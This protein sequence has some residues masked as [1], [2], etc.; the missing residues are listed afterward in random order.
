[1]ADK[2][3]GYKAY[4]YFSRYSSVPMYSDSKGQTYHGITKWIDNDD[5]NIYVCKQ[6]DTLEKIAFKEYGSPTLW[7]VVADVNRIINPALELEMNQKL[8]LIPLGNLTYIKR[9]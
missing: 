8:K 4:N 7:W 1:M 3:M 9:I 6:G 2:N 5:A